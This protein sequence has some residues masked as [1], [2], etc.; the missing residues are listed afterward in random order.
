V[1]GGLQEA[2]FATKEDGELLGRT[3]TDAGK[4][5]IF[6]RRE[7]TEPERSAFDLEKD[8]RITSLRK[9]REQEVVGEF[10]RELKERTEISYDP[11]ALGQVM[12][13][14]NVPAT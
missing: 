4:A 6:Q 1:I 11:G 8:A 14:G 2:A 9:Q 3:F 13:A 10:L 7:L 12:P 5:Y